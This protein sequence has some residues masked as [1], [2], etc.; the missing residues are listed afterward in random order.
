MYA[1][2]EIQIMFWQHYISHT[3]FYA[4]GT[5]APSWHSLHEHGEDKSSHGMWSTKL[6]LFAIWWRNIGSGTSGVYIIPG[7]W[8]HLI[9]NNH[10]NGNASLFIKIGNNIS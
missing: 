7:V 9:N 4:C 3:S 6:I 5:T 1:Q 2:S 10:Q 8:N